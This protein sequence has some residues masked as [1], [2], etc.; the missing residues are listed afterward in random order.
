MDWSIGVICCALAIALELSERTFAAS[1]RLI[2]SARFAFTSD[3]AA[4]SGRSS[5][6]CAWSSASV[7]WVMSHL[8]SG[9]LG[10]RALVALVVKEGCRPFSAEENGPSGSAESCFSYVFREAPP[11]RSCKECV[12]PKRG[13]GGDGFEQ[14]LGDVEVREHVLHVVAFFQLVDQA[15]DLLRVRLL[16]NGHGRLGNHRQLSVLDRVARLLERLA[17]DGQIL[18]RR[19]DFVARAVE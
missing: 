16:R 1:A 6:S 4:R 9:G 7:S 18:R 13:L 15:Q 19:H 8:L 3:I 2:G 14:R 5:A 12:K 10:G 11:I 17:H